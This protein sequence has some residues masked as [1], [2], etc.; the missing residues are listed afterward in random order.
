MKF[1]KL[2]IFPTHPA[3]EVCI[4]IYGAAIFDLD[5]A[6]QLSKMNF[7]TPQR[8]TSLIIPVI[9]VT[10]WTM[11]GVSNSPSLLPNR[12]QLKSTCYEHQQRVQF[13]HTSFTPDNKKLL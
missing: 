8:L 1:S 7:L 12:G 3:H 6:T 11:E 2:L 9:M 4:F 13:E 10:T 5:V